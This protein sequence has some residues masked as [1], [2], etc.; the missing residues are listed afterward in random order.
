[1]RLTPADVHNVAFSKPPIGKRGY[2][3]DEVDQ[4]LDFVEAELSRLI[5]ENTEPPPGWRSSSPNSP[6]PARPS[7]PR[8]SPPGRGAAPAPAYTAPE[9]SRAAND[10]ANTRAARALARAGH[11]R[12]RHLHGARRVE[13]LRRCAQPRRR[14]RR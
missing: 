4:F 1:M 8:R 5:G 3:E 2:N 10:D 11:R 12:S 13:T 7:P 6:T 9:P 14:H